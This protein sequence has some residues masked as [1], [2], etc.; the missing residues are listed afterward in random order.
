M[1]YL[2]YIIKKI[3]IYKINI[4]SNLMQN[5]F[6]RFYFRMKHYPDAFHPGKYSVN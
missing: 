4:L 2:F 5:I 1:K 3:Y 6:D